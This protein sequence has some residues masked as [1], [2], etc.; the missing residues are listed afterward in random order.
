MSYLPTPK[1][2]MQF[3][4][5]EHCLH[6]S[7]IIIIIIIIAV[8]FMKTFCGFESFYSWC[9]QL[10]VFRQTNEQCRKKKG[11]RTPAP[12]QVTSFSMVTTVQITVY[13]YIMPHVTSTSDLPSYM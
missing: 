12:S 11:S 2:D 4:L 10:L 9:E 5:I 6:Y 8:I 13:L 1:L 7:I 3:C